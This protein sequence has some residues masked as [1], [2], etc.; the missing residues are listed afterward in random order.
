MSL[1]CLLFDP[2]QTTYQGNIR[3]QWRK[4]SHLRPIYLTSLKVSC[5]RSFGKSSSRGS[6]D[7]RGLKV[8]ILEVQYWIQY[9]TLVLCT[10]FHCGLVTLIKKHWG[11][12]VLGFGEVLEQAGRAQ[13]NTNSNRIWEA[14]VST[15]HHPSTQAL[16]LAY[17]QA[18]GHID[19]RLIKVV[20][21]AQTLK[22]KDF[23]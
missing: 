2:H 15:E 7:Y 18:H 16:F 3:V 6:C 4:T 11:G 20:I 9:S 1:W 21:H 14:K 22:W 19:L 8:N 5:Q 17:A 13:H 23:L 10:P 12:K